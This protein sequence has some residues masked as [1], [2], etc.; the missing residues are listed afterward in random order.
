MTPTLRTGCKD[1]SESNDITGERNSK[2]E[3]QIAAF[4][5]GINLT[6]IPYEDLRWGDK[7]LLRSKLSFSRSRKG[8]IFCSV[9]TGR[10]TKAVTGYSS[11]NLHF[12]ACFKY[13]G[14]LSH[15]AAWHPWPRR[16]PSPTITFI[17]NYDIDFPRWPHKLVELM[18]CHALPVLFCLSRIWLIKSLGHLRVVTSL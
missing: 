8:T 4:C 10:E 1:Q 15:S 16:T 14:S 5:T 18:A 7:T 13:L 9:L 2:L 12:K 17:I 11:H 6:A 3:T